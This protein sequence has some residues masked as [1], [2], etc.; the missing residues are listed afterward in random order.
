MLKFVNFG[1]VFQEIPD[2]VTLSINISNCPCRCHGCHSN[3]LW[4][5]IG[6]ILDKKVIDDFINKYGNDITCIC[7]MG[8][9][10]NPKEVEDLSKYIHNNY[11]DL[12]VGWY[13]GREKIADNIDIEN[14]DYIKI[15]PYIEELGGLKSKTTNQKLYRKINNKE[16]E[17]I[18]SR[19]WAK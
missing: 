13:S 12:K 6:K 15:G 19:F 14:F 7:F 8:G 2:E 18:T 3:Y 10:V 5:D 1:I 16:F 17:D 4:Q 11:S 9:D